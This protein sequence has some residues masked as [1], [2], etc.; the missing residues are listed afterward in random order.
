MCGIKF[1]DTTVILISPVLHNHLYVALRKP[2]SNY[3]FYGKNSHSLTPQRI[4]SLHILWRIYFKNFVSDLKEGKVPKKAILFV[5]RL[6]DLMEI[7]DF[8]NDE[9]GHL[10]V[11]QNPNTCPWVTNSSATGVVTAEKIRQRAREENSSIYLYI[12]TS[13][14][15]FGLDIKDVSIVI[16][17]SPF[18]TLNSIIQAGGRAGRRQGDGKRK[19]SVVYTLFNGTD[20]RKNTP[21]ETAVRDF[22]NES[23]CLKKK[24]NSQFSSAP[25]PQQDESWCCSSCSL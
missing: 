4:G 2:P 15:L 7:D 3:G 22:C 14:M 8:L 16:L 21:M 9:L 5:K 1:S 6:D 13:V 11:A 18:H 23:Q 25:I 20:L 12:T 10:T 17:F 24:M 19:K